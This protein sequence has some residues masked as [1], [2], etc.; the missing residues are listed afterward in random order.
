MVDM[1]ADLSDICVNESCRHM[2]C[3]D[4]FA[5]I[6]CR[7]DAADVGEPGAVLRCVRHAVP[8]GCALPPPLSFIWF[9]LQSCIGWCHAEGGKLLEAR[10]N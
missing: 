9:C 2:Q 1:H 4:D 7:A 8:A 10:C 6:I 3:S 5:P